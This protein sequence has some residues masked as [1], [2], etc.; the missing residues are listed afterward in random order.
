MTKTI[1]ELEKNID[2]AITAVEAAID[3]ADAAYKVLWAAN[4][5]HHEALKEVKND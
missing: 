3:A 1:E 4:D 2:D 5:A